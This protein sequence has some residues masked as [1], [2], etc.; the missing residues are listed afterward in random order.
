PPPAQAGGNGGVSR[1]V[2][3][4]AAGFQ[5]AVV[6]VLVGKTVQAAEEVGAKQV[7]LAGGVA[8]NKRLREVMLARAKVPVLI[9]D[10]DLCTDNAAMV[11]AAAYF[12][13]QAGDVS[14]LDLDVKPS[15]RLG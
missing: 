3:Q 1:H 5:E 14:G 8:A 2:T 13:L 9:P 4:L 7:A 11:A 6:D 12:R 10:V 15:L